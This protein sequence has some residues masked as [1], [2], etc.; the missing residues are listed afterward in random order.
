[1]GSS[2]NKGSLAALNQSF[3]SGLGAY[4]SAGLGLTNPLGLNLGAGTLPLLQTTKLQNPDLFAQQEI[5]NMNQELLTRLQNLNLLGIS[6]ATAVNNNLPSYL[7]SGASAAAA[8]AGGNATSAAVFQQ[9]GSSGS[10]AGQTN[11][12]TNVLN[13]PTNAG[14]TNPSPMGTLSR[15]S[16]ASSS[17]PVQDNNNMLEKDDFGMFIRPLSQVGTLTTIDGDGKV[18]VIVPMDRDRD[19][20]RDGR[21]RDQRDVN[22]NI[23]SGSNQQRHGTPTKRE[24]KVS[25][26]GIVT[27]DE[28]GTMRRM[29]STGSARSGSATPSFITRSSSEKVPSRSQMMSEMQRTQWARHTT[30]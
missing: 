22:A 21:E 5:L 3:G 1:M 8:N 24:K 6:P 23:S 10:S 16:Y 26:P 9:A 25:I 29:A 18:K 12:N 30:K 28:R 14:S 17:S 20:D 13:T 4:G 27:T 15:K 2:A 19:R 11:N 7:F